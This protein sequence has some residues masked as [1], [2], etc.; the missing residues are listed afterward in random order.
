MRLNFELD[1]DLLSAKRDCVGICLT[2]NPVNYPDHDEWIYSSYQFRIS[3]YPYLPNLTC[4]DVH[5]VNQWSGGWMF[6]L[7]VD[8]LH[9]FEIT[10]S[11]GQPE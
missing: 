8:G 1:L 3:T 10:V 4:A 5:T 11:L 9:S 2:C 7:I 6:R